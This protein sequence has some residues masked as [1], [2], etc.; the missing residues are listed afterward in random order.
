MDST[1]PMGKGPVQRQER[2]WSIRVKGAGQ[3]DAEEGSSHGGKREKKT[4]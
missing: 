2:F 1:N 3:G 4:P